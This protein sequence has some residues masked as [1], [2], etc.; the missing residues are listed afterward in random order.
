MQ[1]PRVSNVAPFW[2]KLVGMRLLS[3]GTRGALAD[4]SEA[5]RRGDARELQEAGKSTSSAGRVIP[6]RRAQRESWCC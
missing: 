2:L 3:R 1:V 6:P 4:V 5:R